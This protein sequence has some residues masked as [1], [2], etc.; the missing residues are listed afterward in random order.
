MAPELQPGDWA[1]GLRCRRVRR[2][3]LVVVEH[4]HRPGFELVKRVT[5]LPGEPVGNRLLAA[6]EY[7]VEGD[8][9]DASTD[10][11]HFGP[12]DRRLIRGRLRLVYWPPPRRRLLRHA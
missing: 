8:A 2:G 9:P 3:D 7:W 10:S 12:V 4:P 1:I 11:R 6:D 5:R